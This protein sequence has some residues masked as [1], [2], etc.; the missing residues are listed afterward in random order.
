MNGRKLLV[1]TQKQIPAKDLVLMNDYEGIEP[2]KIDLVYAFADHS[3]NIFKS[4]I[5]HRECQVLLGFVTL[6]SLLVVFGIMFPA[7][8]DYCKIAQ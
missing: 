4:E 8:A 6:H 1:K 7:P 3:E 5:A 2:V